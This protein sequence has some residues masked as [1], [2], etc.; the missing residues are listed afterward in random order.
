MNSSSN[1]NYQPLKPSADAN[2]HATDF[3]Y[4]SGVNLH[5]ENFN[6]IGKATFSQPIV[7]RATDTFMVKL[8]M[9]F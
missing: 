7:K 5:D 8:K 6:I 9:D 4:I 1:P 3:V 2:E